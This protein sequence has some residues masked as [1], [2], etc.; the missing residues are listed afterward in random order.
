MGCHPD[1]HDRSRWLRAEILGNHGIGGVGA[2]NATGG[3]GDWCGHAAFRRINL[4]GVSLS[5]GTL[6]FYWDHNSFLFGS[7]K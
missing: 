1:R 7:K 4:K 3:A 2:I 5:A 6:K